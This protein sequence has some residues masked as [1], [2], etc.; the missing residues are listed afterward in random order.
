MEVK[1]KV[2]LITIGRSSL[3]LYSQNIGAD[4]KDIKGFNA[5]VGGSP[6]NIAVGSSRLGLKSEIFNCSR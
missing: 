3:D 6:L 1:K 2:D 5:Y 4:F